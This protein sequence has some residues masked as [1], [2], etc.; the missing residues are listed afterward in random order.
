MATQAM[1]RRVSRRAGASDMARLANDYQRQAQGLAGQYET[2]FTN[3]KNKVA[4]QMAPFEQAMQQY[5]TQAMPAYESALAQYQQKYDA[6]QAQ[7]AEIA[8]NPVTER[9]ERVVVGKKWYGKKKYGNVTFFD[10]KPIPTFNEKAP[11]RPNAPDAPQIAEF[12][13][14]EFEQRKGQLQQDFS[15][16]VGERKGARLQ[17]T[18][19]ASRTMLS[20]AKQ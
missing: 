11:D 3:Y 20:G 4:Q 15:R 12:D 1:M 16:E 5:Q 19:R 9:V 13:S 18:R 17:A 14:S 7:L 6:H 10:P 2:E 8:A